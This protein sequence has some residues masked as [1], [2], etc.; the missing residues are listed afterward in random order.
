MSMR[1]GRRRLRTLGDFAREIAIIVVGVLIALAASDYAAE[2]D[3]RERVADAERQL[4][5]EAGQNFL[6]AAELFATE[7]CVQAQ[8]EALRQRVLGS[9]DR[10]VPAPMHQDAFMSFVLR[11]PARP[12]G[13]AIW[14]ALGA[15]GTAAHFD[16]ARSARYA[17]N[18][19]QLANMRRMNAEAER[20]VGRLRVLGSDVPL[21]DT[22]RVALLEAIGEQAYRSR[23]QSVMAL[24]VMAAIRDLGHAGDEAK[25]ARDLAEASGTLQFCKQQGLPLADWRGTLAQVPRR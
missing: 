17:E 20:I 13:N 23:L 14:E 25:V 3:R 1:P 9:G 8:L 19:A 11:V 18:G 5:L 24:Q 16:D 22:T 10:L 7:P 6:Y 2:R 15:D 12:F 4:A 21:D